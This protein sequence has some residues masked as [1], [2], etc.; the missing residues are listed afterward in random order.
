MFG[1]LLNILQRYSFSS[2]AKYVLFCPHTSTW[3]YMNV[4]FCSALNTEFFEKNTVWTNEKW[5]RYRQ[6]TETAIY[7]ATP[8]I[9][10]FGTSKFLSSPFCSFPE[11]ESA[12]I[13][14]VVI[15]KWQSSS[16]CILWCILVFQYN[17]LNDDE[18]IKI[19]IKTTSHYMIWNNH[20][21]FK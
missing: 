14:W 3:K 11:Q 16:H 17:S 10:I 12:T 18:K 7:P 13:R 1:R 5:K 9:Y 21:D 19:K 8:V 6:N 20:I 2:F 15:H 4:R